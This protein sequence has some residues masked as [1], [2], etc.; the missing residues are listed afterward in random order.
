[1]AAGLTRASILVV[2]VGVVLLDHGKGCRR[3]AVR[4]GSGWHGRGV[5]FHGAEDAGVRGGEGAE[6]NG[7]EEVAAAEDGGDGDDGNE[8][9]R[10][11]GDVVHCDDGVGGEVLAKDAGE[12]ALVADVLHA[13]VEA[14]GGVDVD[15]LA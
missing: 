6:K 1:M 3:L 5:C 9:V 14:A 11:D 4:P 12:E 15:G 13:H 2:G 7:G 8:E 10:V